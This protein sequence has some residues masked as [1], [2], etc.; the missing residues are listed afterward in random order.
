VLFDLG[1]A[2]LG[3]GADEEEAPTAV[4]YLP[5][6]GVWHGTLPT[7][8]GAA[9]VQ[10]AGIGSASVVKQAYV[11]QRFASWAAIGGEAESSAAGARVQAQ[12]QGEAT[13]L[14]ASPA[15]VP[16]LLDTRKAGWAARAELAAAQ[17]RPVHSGNLRAML[18]PRILFSRVSDAT[19][20]GAR[21]GGGGSEGGAQ[22]SQ[23]AAAAGSAPPAPAAAGAA[24]LCLRALVIAAG[25]AGEGP[26]VTMLG[27]SW[28]GTAGGSGGAD[29]AVF[30]LLRTLSRSVLLSL[31]PAAVSAA[32]LAEAA[33][34]AAEMGTDGDD[35]SGAVG[36]AQASQ[37]LLLAANGR[38]GS[39]HGAARAMVRAAA[40][41]GCRT[42]LLCSRWLNLSVGGGGSTQRHGCGG[43]DLGRHAVA[44]VV[45]PSRAALRA[46]LAAAAASL[47][48]A[49]ALHFGGAA[50]IACSAPA[51][52]AAA[53]SAAGL[54]ALRRTADV[55]VLPE[56]L[57]RGDS[58]GG[59][60][61]D[62][63]AQ[64]GVASDDRRIAFRVTGM[65]SKH[66]GRL[67][68]FTSVE[69]ARVVG[70]VL[71]RTHAQTARAELARR[72][73]ARTV[74]LEIYGRLLLV[75]VP[76]LPA[77]QPAEM[78]KG[79]AAAAKKRRRLADT[80]GIES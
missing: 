65:R 31:M 56:L 71:A 26:L 19:A 27:G 76:L 14:G 74:R 12:V 38:A 32:A 46:T 62:G 58:D 17:L 16:A 54:D 25:S 42:T 21:G 75:T 52:P 73:S 66:G 1:G 6:S 69:A 59:G 33:E 63:E 35:G 29:A 23:D 4:V 70:G 5:G 43:G 51:L 28:Q 78:A 7:A 30:R 67:T 64:A 49:V 22:P 15:Q 34:V 10:H 2:G 60:V 48:D 39:G 13:E 61:A 36:S 20:A 44:R 79:E 24:S 72:A 40:R 9:H 41:H 45:G 3:K 37:V 77:A 18:A 80:H 68:S 55:L 50:R 8:F 11:G 57:L 47:G 53:G